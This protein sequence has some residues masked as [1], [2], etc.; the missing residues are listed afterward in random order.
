MGELSREAQLSRKS[1][2]KRRRLRVAR[3]ESTL[4]RAM[5]TYQA[6]KQN[7]KQSLLRL[8]RQYHE[9]QAKRKRHWARERRLRQELQQQV[10]SAWERA[11]QASRISSTEYA[12]ALN[13][14]RGRY[15]SMAK[16]A[17]E[18]IGSA[19]QAYK[20]AKTMSEGLQAS[21]P[22]QQ[23]PA[24]L[25]QMV[26][27]HESRVEAAR[28]HWIEVVRNQ[29]QRMQE[30]Q[31][32]VD[33]LRSE[34]KQHQEAAQARAQQSEQ[35]ILEQHQSQI[36]AIGAEDDKDKQDM[37]AQRKADNDKELADKK[38]AEDRELQLSLER[39]KQIAKTQMNVSAC[40]CPPR[41]EGRGARGV[42]PALLC[43]AVTCCTVLV[44]SI[45][46]SHCLVRC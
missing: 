35:K 32:Q 5:T 7:M 16:E 18:A 8:E 42:A 11:K 45:G 27:E 29:K 3:E 43:V 40:G 37:E 34:A 26:N 9:A 17:R 44:L 2:L 6:D 39:Q 20:K 19:Y 13:E 23:L 46:V 15:T 22:G 14:A 41:G 21:K 31:Q 38:D 10:Q 36:Q 33:R 28:Q 25:Q 30:W 24:E 4:R 12:N 1:E